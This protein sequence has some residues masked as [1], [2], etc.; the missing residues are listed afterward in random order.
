MCSTQ[1]AYSLKFS[2][3]EVE[4]LDNFRRLIIANPSFLLLTVRLDYVCGETTGVFVILR[5]FV[6]DKN[7]AAREQPLSDYINKQH[8]EASSC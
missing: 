8:D 5:Y 3:L 7:S 2:L 6:N 1:S 4:Q